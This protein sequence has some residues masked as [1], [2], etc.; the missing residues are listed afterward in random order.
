MNF[1][2]ISANL[3]N[4]VWNVTTSTPQVVGPALEKT[5]RKKDIDAVAKG[6]RRTVKM[7][8]D[9]NMGYTITQVVTPTS[10]EISIDQS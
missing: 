10:V 1:L 3:Q 6:T 8:N 5:T 9:N 4:G 2:K 7:L